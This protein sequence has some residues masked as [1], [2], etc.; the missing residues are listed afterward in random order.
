MHAIVVFV[1]IMLMLFCRL[2]NDSI[3]P[4]TT[5]TAP[6]KPPAPPVKPPAPPVKPT[7][8]PVKPTA[9]P[10]KPKHVKPKHVKP[11][12]SSNEARNYAGVSYL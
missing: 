12:Q 3:E 9:P 1:I 2:R 5:L 6:V 11:V 7:A 10:V 4:L 8:P